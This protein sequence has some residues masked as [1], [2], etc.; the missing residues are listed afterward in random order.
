MPSGAITSARFGDPGLGAEVSGRSRHRYLANTPFKLAKN[1]IRAHVERVDAEAEGS[2]TGQRYK[3]VKLVWYD[4]P[5]I[6][7]W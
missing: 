6:T 4:V 2:D 7:Q 5:E 3:L 1:R